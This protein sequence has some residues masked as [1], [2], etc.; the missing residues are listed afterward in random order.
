MSEQ[1]R[2]GELC[3][4][5][6]PGE[7]LFLTL[8]DGRSVRVRIG[9]VKDRSVRLFIRAPADIKIGRSPAGEE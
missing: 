7:A 2:Q 3:T 6:R 9:H 5:R 8:P 1:Q 4:L